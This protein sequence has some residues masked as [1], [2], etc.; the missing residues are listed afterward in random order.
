MIDVY[1]G[2]GSNLDNPLNQIRKALESIDLHADIQIKAISSFYGNPP[3]GPTDQPNFV[4]AVAKLATTMPALDL[5][6]FLQGIERKQNRVKKMHWGPRTIDLDILLYGVEMI[7]L[8]NLMIP[9]P[10][11][12]QRPFVVWPLLEIAPDL[13]LPNLIPLKQIAKNLD[14]NLLTLV[15]DEHDYTVA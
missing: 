11:L 12:T 8:P 10:G 5:L 4:N 3:M 6:N 1:I 14:N 13:I 7:N 2:L 15:R 9:H